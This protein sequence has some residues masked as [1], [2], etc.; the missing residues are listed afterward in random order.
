VYC[1]LLSHVPLPLPAASPFGPPQKV[2]PTTLNRQGN[3]VGTQYRSTIFYHNEAQKEAA[4]KVGVGGRWG[5]VGIGEG[6]VWGG[7]GERYAAAPFSSTFLRQPRWALQA[8]AAA[9]KSLAKNNLYRLH[10]T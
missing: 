3:D 6:L 2:D 7:C 4:E 10:Q 1:A 8:V 9:N 5:W